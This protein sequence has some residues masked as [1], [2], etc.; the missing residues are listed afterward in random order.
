MQNVSR[1][2]MKNLT[3]IIVASFIV[4]SSCKHKNRDISLSQQDHATIWFIENEDSLHSEFIKVVQEQLENKNYDSSWQES[5]FQSRDSSTFMGRFSLEI[6]RDCKGLTVT[7]FY[8]KGTEPHSKIL[9]ST[10]YN[11]HFVAALDTILN[12]VE[13][14]KF[15]TIEK[16]EQPDIQSQRYRLKNFTINKNDIRIFI[17]EN[18]QNLDLKVFL[19][20]KDKEA[21]LYEEEK[22]FIK[23]SLFGEELL[24]KKINSCDF[25]ITDTI[26]FKLMAYSK[27][28]LKLML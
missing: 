18:N 17:K 8:N 1:H 16:F 24:L 3:I 19:Y 6:Q 23:K 11:K 2:T 14:P 12:V 15:F 5:A 20:A 27:A 9:V 4:T 22:E 21:E 10:E 7:F 13:K 26:D 25:F 28:M